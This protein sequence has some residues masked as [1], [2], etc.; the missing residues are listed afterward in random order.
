MKIMQAPSLNH[1][2]GIHTLSGAPRANAG[3]T[4][5]EL[6]VVVAIV[7]IL[8]ALAAPSFTP[9]IERWRVRNAAE[10][11][12][13][14]F[15]YARSEAIKSGGGIAIDATGGWDK[16]WKVTHTQGGT[17]TERQV[18]VPPSKITLAQSNSKEKLYADRWGMLSETSSGAP[19]AGMSI[20][21]Y[22]TG[23][24]TTDISAIRLC[25]SGGGRIAQTKQGAACPT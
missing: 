19:S 16:G 14:T 10:D 4:M 24:T 5:I 25:I 8:A 2:S 7:G 6:M 1:W 9:V 17:T 13:S 20:L 23:K 11:L 3:F 15:Y 21:I 22:P 18:S 12:T